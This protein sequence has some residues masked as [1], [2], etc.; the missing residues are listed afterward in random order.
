[1]E[2]ELLICVGLSDE[3]N[4]KQLLPSSLG[5]SMTYMGSLQR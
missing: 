5:T 1:M 2:V 3:L 4:S